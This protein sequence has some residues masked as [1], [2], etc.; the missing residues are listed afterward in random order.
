MNLVFRCSV[1]RWLLYCLTI[2]LS[3][4]IIHLSRLK[5]MSI[6][7]ILILCTVLSVLD[8]INPRKTTQGGLGMYVIGPISR[9]TSFS[10][11]TACDVTECE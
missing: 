3:Y 5:C 10:C 4:Y 8:V 6:S 2:D 11:L 7:F 1:F 9:I